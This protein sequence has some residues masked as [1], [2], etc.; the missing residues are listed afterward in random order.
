MWWHQ[1]LTSQSSFS[2]LLAEYS[3]LLG[4]VTEQDVVILGRELE[5]GDPGDLIRRVEDLLGKTK[6]K[7]GASKSVMP[8]DSSGKFIVG[9]G[10]SAHHDVEKPLLRGTQNQVK[11][12]HSELRVEFSEPGSRKIINMSETGN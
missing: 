3:D 4:L 8:K 1:P 6:A 5:S 11:A 7:D 12:E 10:N 9:E 2:R